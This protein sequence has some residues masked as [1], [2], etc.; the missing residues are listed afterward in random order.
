[1]TNKN[2]INSSY[3]GKFVKQIKKVIKFFQKATFQQKNTLQQIQLTFIYFFAIVVLFYSIRGSLGFFPETLFTIFPFF[4]QI[5]EIQILKL[6]ATPEKT[7]LL[8]LFVLEYLI[9]RSI[10]N[11]SLLVK[12]NI[13]LIFL[14]EMMQNLIIS[15]WDLL[16]SR[17]V[18]IFPATMIFSKNSTIFFFSI[19]F[20]FFFLIYFYSYVRGLRGLYPVLPGFLEFINQSV[21]FWLQIKITKEKKE[22]E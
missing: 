13:L 16:F 18:E 9:N 11:L 2:S 5:L 3:W 8:Y 6:F 15:Y 7:F 12:F 1:M 22:G 4:H 19:F 20:V 10:F 21:A 17:D 14:L